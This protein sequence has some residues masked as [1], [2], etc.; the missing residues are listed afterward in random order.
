MK[1]QNYDSNKF[2]FL[3][4]W[5]YRDKKCSTEQ[6]SNLHPLHVKWWLMV[7]YSIQL[8]SS[9]YIIQWKGYHKNHFDDR[10]KGSDFWTVLFTIDLIGSKFGGGF[11]LQNFYTQQ[12]DLN[13][14]FSY[15]IYAKL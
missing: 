3:L 5:I 1:N 12:L 15:N 14:D 6:D 4:E 2:N 10:L 8:W 13:D 7:S 9:I 11:F